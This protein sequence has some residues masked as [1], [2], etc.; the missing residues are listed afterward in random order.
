[1]KRRSDIFIYMKILALLLDGPRG[2]TSLAQGAGLNYNKFLDFANFLESRQCIRK[3]LEE[4]HEV[5]HL[6]N[7]G[8]ELHEYITKVAER[9]GRN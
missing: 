8:I 9:L 4:D 5:Y 2:P 6:T 7:E 1:L 3:E